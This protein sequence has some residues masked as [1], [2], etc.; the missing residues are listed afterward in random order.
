M[1]VPDREKGRGFE[2]PAR[3]PCVTDPFSGVPAQ[4]RPLPRKKGS[5]RRVRC[6]SCGREYWTNRRGELCLDG[7]E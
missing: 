6:A 7:D 3:C 2:R 4:L 5:L 1:A